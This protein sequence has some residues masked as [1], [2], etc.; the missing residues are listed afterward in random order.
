MRAV[1]MKAAEL[2]LTQLLVRDFPSSGG[3]ESGLHAA[4]LS[5]S[6]LSRW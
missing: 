2:S 6:V 4:L 3:A 1:P 5:L